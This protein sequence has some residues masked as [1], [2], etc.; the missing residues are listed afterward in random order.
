MLLS[1]AL[2][3]FDISHEEFAKVINEKIK[4]ER[5]KENVKNITSKQVN[6]NVSGRETQ[7]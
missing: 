3:D 2:T 1:S 6:E 4:Y 7:L 5:V